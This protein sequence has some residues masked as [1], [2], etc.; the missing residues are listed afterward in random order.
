MSKARFALWCAT[1][2]ITACIFSSPANAQY[3][4]PPDAYTIAEVNSMFGPTVTMQIYRDGS[5]VLVDQNHEAQG[6]GQGTHVRTLY[7]LG[8]HR[9]FTWD[10]ANRAVP[11]G[12]GTFSGDWGDPFAFS[13]EMNADLAK[14]K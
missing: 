5:K 12:G 3:A 2:V 11:C 8:T 13:A 14:Q 10:V 6:G 1:L 9:N 7:D 4:P